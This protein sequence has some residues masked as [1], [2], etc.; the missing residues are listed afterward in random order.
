MIPIPFLVIN[1]EDR[2]QQFFGQIEIYELFRAKK[3]GRPKQNSESI[4]IIFS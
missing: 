3:P 4:Y 1:D 2:H